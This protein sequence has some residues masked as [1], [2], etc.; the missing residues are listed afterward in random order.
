MLTIFGWQNSQK[1]PHQ[2][3]STPDSTTKPPVHVNSTIPPLAH[4]IECIASRLLEGNEISGTLIDAFSQLTRLVGLYVLY[5]W[6]VLLSV[7]VL[8]FSEMSSNSISGTISSVMT[9][10]T[11]IY[12]LCVLAFGSMMGCDCVGAGD[13]KQ[14]GSLG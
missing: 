12:S 9:A 14:T 7:G 11:R 4:A 13:L 5:Y 3:D 2:R 1:E 10:L 6:R 8:T